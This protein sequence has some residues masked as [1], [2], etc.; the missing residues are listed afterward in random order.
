MNI[1]KKLR[2]RVY[3]GSCG[4]IK[5]RIKNENNSNILKNFNPKIASIKLLLNK[6][7]TRFKS[8]RH[9]ESSLI[10]AGIFSKKLGKMGFGLSLIDL[11]LELTTEKDI[12]TVI[13]NYD[14]L[15]NFAFDT[16]L[17]I[18][19]KQNQK[20]DFDNGW[21]LSVLET[22]NL[23]KET[24]TTEFYWEGAD[25]DEPLHVYS[26]N[27]PLLKNHLR[28]FLFKNNKGL[29]FSAD[30]EYNVK[31]SPIEN[32]SYNLPDDIKNIADRLDKFD[33]K[34]SILLYGEPGTGK[35]TAAR[36]LASRN[37]WKF[38]SVSAF[39]L[40]LD[41]IIGI[42]DC[43]QPDAIIFDDFDRFS[44]VSDYL[45]G[46]EEIKKRCPLVI[47][48]INRY[49]SIDPALTRPE[50]FDDHFE[51]S[52]VDEIYIR[53]LLINNLTNIPPDIYNEIKTWPIVYIKSFNDR[54]DKLGI[55]KIQEEFE[56]LKKR[57]IIQRE[58]YLDEEDNE[59]DYENEE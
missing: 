33:N 17:R 47:A 5:R 8:I 46:L 4:M 15:I 59:V 43:L 1:S 23:N 40:R 20:Y 13:R 45:S 50:R 34:I 35:S 41:N 56:I 22:E 26:K 54:I 42:L 18:I 39:S 3:R 32:E 9:I 16:E 28:E 58:E 36:L 11:F 6:C 51:I 44:K 30:H 31:I 27:I 14:T 57:L 49:K 12:F 19:L 2:A 21:F 37:N 29:Y 7:K 55:D 25:S 53:K 24:I 52:H 38:I 10:S 48:T